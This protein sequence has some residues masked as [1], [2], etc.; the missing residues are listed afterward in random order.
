MLTSWMFPVIL[1]TT[2]TADCSAT[3]FIPYR[4]RELHI[5]YFDHTNPNINP[6]HKVARTVKLRR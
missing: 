1:C 6:L 4:N 5:L 2:V 3:S